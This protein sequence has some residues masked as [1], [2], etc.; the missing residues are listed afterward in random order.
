LIDSLALEVRDIIDGE[1]VDRVV[2]TIPAPVVCKPDK[3]IDERTYGNYNRNMDKAEKWGP[4]GNAWTFGWKHIN[5][6]LKP[7]QITSDDVLIDVGSGNGWYLHTIMQ[8]WNIKE[9]AGIDPS[10][11]M[12]NE[13]RAHE[14]QATFCIGYGNNLTIAGVPSSY[15]TKLIMIYPLNHMTTDEARSAIREAFRVLKPGGKLIFSHINPP[16]LRH[17]HEDEEN[18]TDKRPWNM[19]SIPYELYFEM[20]KELEIKN[21]IFARCKGD[22]K[23]TYNCANPERFHIYWS[24]EPRTKIDGGVETLVLRNK[25]NFVI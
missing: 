19:D 25:L 3:E 13:A 21:P 5:A 20:A 4:Q 6:L 7:L 18:G 10:A 16:G 15:F 12:V 17:T 1:W 22:N 9:A 11:R 24:K 2:D 23:Y 14:K 8:R